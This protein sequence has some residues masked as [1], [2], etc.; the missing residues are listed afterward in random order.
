MERPSPD[1]LTRMPLAEA[2]LLL[3]RWGA[4][5]QRL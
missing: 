4:D 1:V 2:V 3:W 5:D